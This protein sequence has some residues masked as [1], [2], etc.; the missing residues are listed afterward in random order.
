MQTL[1]TT[2]VAALWRYLDYAEHQQLDT[3]SALAAAGISSTQLQDNNQR[4]SLHAFEVLLSHLLAQRPQPLFGLNAA[5]HVQ[6][7]SWHVLGYITMNC[8]TLGDALA[9]IIPYE[10]LVSD[11]G[12]S[13]LQNNGRELELRWYCQHQQP[14][15]RQQLSEHVLAAWLLYAQWLTDTVSA[16]LKVCFAHPQPADTALEDYQAFFA[17]PVL[18]QQPH[19][20]LVIATQ[21]LQLPVRQADAMLLHTLEQ[22]ASSLLNQ[23]QTPTEQPFSEQVKLVITE[24][25]SSRIPRQEEIAQRCN[26]T[27]RTLQRRLQEAGTHYQQLLD[28]VRF[29]QAKNQLINTQQALPS[30]A[31]QLGFIEPRSFF[32]FF[33]RRAGVTPGVY[34]S[35]HSE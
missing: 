3:Q 27:L 28:E 7:A 1:G 9:R 6:P 17:C 33:K 30:I 32:R 13:E 11:S 23:L 4:V 24:V 31:E 21:H 2:S 20:C 10:K 14:V 16:P 19:N 25:L 29:T 35:Q 5:R 22:H 8:A 18:F 26:M 12:T 15:L 34:R